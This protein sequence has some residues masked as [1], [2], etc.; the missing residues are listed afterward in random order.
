VENRG[1]VT[2]EFSRLVAADEIGRGGLVIE[3]SANAEERAAL[4]ERFGLTA[5]NNFRGRA[6]LSA[7]TDRRIR[8]EVTFDADVLQSC[9]ITLEPVASHISDQF[10]VVYAPAT[11]G[12]DEAEVIIDV[13]SEDPPEPLLEGK[14]DVGEM[15]AQHLA[16]LIDPY[17][18]AP[19]APDGSWHGNDDD[20]A[21]Q[22]GSPFD[23]LK[24]WKTRR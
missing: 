5:L 12:E 17:P 7:L 14:I 9:V 19:D 20:G 11:D 13:A 3:L 1:P 21:A 15:M 18:R 8:L 22:A 2:I 24:Q 6:R 23:K 10:E 4:A 16:M